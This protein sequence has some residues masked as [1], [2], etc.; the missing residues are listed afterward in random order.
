MARVTVSCRRLDSCAASIGFAIG[1]ASSRT[2]I[3]P[4]ASCRRRRGIDL[5]GGC[6]SNPGNGDAADDTGLDAADD[7]GFGADAREDLER[8]V[9][10]LARVRRGA[11]RAQ[12]AAVL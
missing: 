12:H 1:S 7:A 11:A 2:S 5:R 8:L 10:L 3:C 6:R 4:P 9:D